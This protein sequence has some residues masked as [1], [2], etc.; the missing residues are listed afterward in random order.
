MYGSCHEINRIQ[1][2]CQARFVHMYINGHNLGLAGKIWLN[3]VHG[4]SSL[5]LTNVFLYINFQYKCFSS[6]NVII[7]TKSH[8]HTCV[9]Q[10]KKGNNCNSINWRLVVL[11]LIKVFLYMK[12]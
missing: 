2:D 4:A 1:K 8:I 9:D 7:R 10:V 11:V 6:K 3:F 12:F 5:R